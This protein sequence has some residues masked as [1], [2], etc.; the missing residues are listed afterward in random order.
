MLPLETASFIWK[1]DIPYPRQE[2]IPEPEGIKRM[3]VHDGREDMLPFLHDVAITRFNGFLYVAWYNST[4]AEICGT[5]LIRGRRSGDGGNTWS[6]PFTIAGCL[7]A[8]NEHYVPITFFPQKDKLYAF[9]TEMSGKNI[10][11]ALHLYVMND[12]GGTE[13]EKVSRVSEG[14]ITNAPPVLLKNGNYAMGAWIPM[15]DESP[16]FPV[17]LISNGKDIK[18][19]W[20]ISF[21]YDPMRPGSVRI[22]CPEISLHAEGAYITAY[23]RNDEGPSYVFTSYDYAENWQPPGINPMHIGNSKIFAGKL[24]DGRNYIIYNEERG[25]FVRTLLVLAVADPGSSSYSRVYRLFDGYESQIGRGKTWFYPC[26]YESDGILY[27]AC[28]LQESTN[29]RSAVMAKVP[30]PSL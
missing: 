5:S 11:T 13:W 12:K 10:T 19:P 17:V 3:V 16:A 21:L 1:A 2:N 15:K 24:S 20:R 26:A 8:E 6:D 23:V 28:T 7:Y 30:I 4:D 14:F 29:I 22:R 9:I 25:Y 27:A 18:R